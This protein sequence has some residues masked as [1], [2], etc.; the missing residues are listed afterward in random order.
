MVH[1]ILPPPIWKSAMC[2]KR[3]LRHARYLNSEQQMSVSVLQFLLSVFKL[4][5]SL[6]FSLQFSDIVNRCF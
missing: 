1:Y 6:L 3:D 2:G 4:F 5:C